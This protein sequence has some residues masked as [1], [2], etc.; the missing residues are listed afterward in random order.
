MRMLVLIAAVLLNAT[1]LA[2]TLAASRSDAIARLEPVIDVDLSSEMGRES[3]AGFVVPELG[4]TLELWFEGNAT[5]ERSWPLLGTRLGIGNAPGWTLSAERSGAWSWNQGNGDARLDYAP[6]AARQPL[7]DGQSHQLVLAVVPQRKEARL[8]HDGRNVAIYSLNGLESHA[9]GGELQ[10]AESVPGQLGRLRIWDRPLDDSQIRDLFAAVRAPEIEPDHTVPQEL[11][12]MAWNIWHGGRE[13]GAETGVQ[14]VIDVIRD[15]G[16]DIVCMQETYGSGPQIADSLG[17][18]FYLRSSNLSVMSRYPLAETYDIFKPFY[19]GGV[20]IQLPDGRSLRAFSTWLYYLPDCSVFASDPST[21]T[22]A[23]LAEE[24]KTR[25]AEIRA[26]VDELEGL[27]VETDEIPL[28]LA[29]D[30]NGSSH[31]DW[32]DQTASVHHGRVVAWPVSTVCADAGL[33]DSY[34][35]VHPDALES[36]GLTWS[37]RFGDDSRIDYIYAKGPWLTPVESVVINTHP[38]RFPSDHAAVVTTYRIQSP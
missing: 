6:T 38:V 23:F 16:A 33:V 27:L 36:R 13:N 20:R 7:F 30:F 12:V 1:G 22:E 25:Q 19:S 29:G 31:L 24:A 8:Y 14:Q 32:T 3:S 5:G 26:I 15:S 35:T 21:D 34:R 18:Y 4:F 9:V 17:F 10:I 28:I 11:R 37:P 2:A